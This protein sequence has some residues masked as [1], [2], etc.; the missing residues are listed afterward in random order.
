M[1]TPQYMVHNIFFKPTQKGYPRLNSDL[2]TITEI[3]CARNLAS[4]C[5]L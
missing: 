3:A 4:L 2:P 5:W 1:K